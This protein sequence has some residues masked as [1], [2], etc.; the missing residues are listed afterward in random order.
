M[1][2]NDMTNNHQLETPMSTYYQAL[3][4]WQKMKS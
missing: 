2:H 3:E 4:N 1:H